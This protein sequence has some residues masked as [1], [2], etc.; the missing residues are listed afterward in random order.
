MFYK[1]NIKIFFYFFIFSLLIITVCIWRNHNFFFFDDSQNEYLGF[2][3]QY[4]LSWRSGEIPFITKNI[5]IG[6]N[7]MI[8]L[9][10]AIFAPH[11]II[12]SILGSYS[13][14][15]LFTGIFFA[16][17]DLLIICFSGYIIGRTLDIKENLSIILG[18]S[19]AINPM[20]L[21][22]Y[23]GAWW[24]AA[25]GHAISLLAIASIFYLIKNKT[26]WAYIFNFIS[27]LWL[28][29]SGWPH[30]SVGYLIT[31]GFLIIFI[32]KLKIKSILNLS[33]PTIC[34]G[35][36]AVPIYSEFIFSKDLLDRFSGFSNGNNF[37][38]PTISQ[39]LFSFSPSYYDY[40]HYVGGYQIFFVPLAFSTIFF[41]F[42]CFF[43]KLNF[44]DPI[45]KNLIGLSIIF[46]I[47]CQSPSQ[48]GM[49]RFSFRFLPFFSL[50]LTILT[51]Y[52]ISKYEIIIIK[53]REKS[54]FIFIITVLIISISTCFFE[55]KKV[56]IT[57]LM[58]FCLLL[59]VYFFFF[60]N[61][62]IKKASILHLSTIPFCCLLIMLFI[63]P[64]LGGRYLFQTNLPNEL[65]NSKSL[66][67]NGYVMPFSKWGADFPKELSDINSSQYGYYNIKTIAGYSPNG[68]KYLDQILVHNLPQSL[69]DEHEV[70]PHL[71]IKFPEYRDVCMI[72]LLNVSTIVLP[73]NTNLEPI[74]QC[75]YTKF[76][77]GS[78]DFIY[79]MNDQ[80][81]SSTLSYSTNP[82]TKIIQETNNT[83]KL[84]IPK[85]D[86]INTLIFSR[87]FWHG[88]ISSGIKCNVEI[89][90]FK[91]ALLSLKIPS[92][93]SGN[94]TLSYF[95]KTWKY[96]L[97]FPVFGIICFIIF[98]IFNNKKDLIVNR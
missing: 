81:S 55:Q 10:R 57:N 91:G 43:F 98:L 88:Y 25:N 75:G 14:H 31:T 2:M 62:K 76:I 60:K 58:S 6:S 50:F 95:P 17:I 28:L 83:I 26:R 67:L 70:L 68:Q 49:L 13:Q 41:V 29:L 93:C 77:S 42:S 64:G 37:L 97:F 16:L 89:S 82:N 59:Y 30:G 94:L 24:N 11:N 35:I 44:N 96:T 15:V 56:L 46:V 19:L 86:N 7:A 18:M 8:E 90:G 21:Y 40:M 20:Y 79:A 52:I 5:M 80:K 3:H 65:H 87:E 54:F 23:S 51:F 4:G 9:Q 32:H 72:N 27:V 71:L 12:A 63:L 61:K 33:I 92:N 39:M 38:V 84:E 45:L 47:V 78:R 48:F 73:K 85:S 53:S 66:N 34:A 74:K 36:C 69:F 1:K 22:Q